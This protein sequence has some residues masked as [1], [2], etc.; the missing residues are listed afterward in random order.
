M[1]VAAAGLFL[2][3]LVVFSVGML[4]GPPR[5]RPRS[6]QH[7]KVS[8]TGKDS[9]A[10]KPKVSDMAAVAQAASGDVSIYFKVEANKD[11]V[12]LDSAKGTID[13]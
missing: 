11:P 5:K 6:G 9:A 10:N 13:R 1:E 8:F 4:S 3:L 12:G 7:D 2:I